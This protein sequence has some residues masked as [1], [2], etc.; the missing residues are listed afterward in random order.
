MADF[1]KLPGIP[2]INPVKDQTLSAILRPIKE[3]IEIIGN[4]VTGLPLP[5][6][7][8]IDAG[9]NPSITGGGTP[10]GSNG[11][12][13]L[14]DYTPPPAP[15]GLSIQ[16]AFSNILLDW[17]EPTYANHAYTEVW[18]AT[19]NSLGAAVLIGFAPGL[20][21]SDSVG[22]HNTYYYWIR[23]VSQAN[24]AGPYNG[25]TG[26]VGI[27]ALDPAYALE[28]LT[29]QIT[30]TQLYSTLSNT[31]NLITA[32][33]STANSVNARV[34]QEASDRAAAVLAEASARATQDQVLQTQIDT[35]VAASSGDFQDLIA[36]I[37]TE[38]TAR[39]AADTAEATARETLAAQMRGTYTGTDV[40]LVTTG[41]MYSER[42]ARASADG[43]LSSSITALSST[44]S[45]NYTTLNSAI[46]TE[47]TTRANADTALSSS[48][49]SVSAIASSKN[50][51]YRQSTA[52]TSPVAGDVWYDTSAENLS[53]RWNGSLW[54]TVQDLR[55]G[56][57]TAAITA[58][59]TARAN[60]DTA[61]ATSITNLTSTVNNNYT[62]LNSAITTESSTRASADTTLSNQITTLQSTVTTNNNTLTA[63]ISTE[64][65]T[66]A[67][68]D[69]GLLAQYTVKVDVNGRVAG[70]GLAST[71]SGGTPTSSFIVIADKFAIVK[72]ADTGGTPVVPFVVGTVDG[73]ST[74]AI[75][76]AVIQDA[77]IT[78]AKIAN[79]AVDSAKIAN[80]AIVSAKIAD[81]NIVTA[82]IAD[83]AI[84]TAKIAN[85]SIGT[86][87]IANAAINTALI[88]DAA[89]TTAKI[90]DANITNV[91]IA[92]AA[93][94]TAKIG[95]AAITTAKIGDATITGAKIAAATIGS[96]NIGDAQITNAK[97]GNAEV[98]T[99]KIA[100]NA[101]TLPVAVYTDG[102]VTVLYDQG[103]GYPTTVQSA[104]ISSSGAP[105]L[106][107]FC[108][109]TDA[110]QPDP[111]TGGAPYYGYSLHRNGAVLT[112]GLLS[113]FSNETLVINFVDTAG[114]GYYTYELRMGASG[115]TYGTVRKR[116]LSIL[117]VK[118]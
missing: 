99:I 17:D 75:S 97:I 20:V 4:A 15:T 100:G 48:I 30:Q 95:D 53:K 107:S 24:V 102:G 57:N 68:V 39:I 50:V 32:P 61:L 31:I 27:T 105:K 36:A 12:D 63:A 14:I 84:T 80:A 115:A 71:T 35:L 2:S 116:T 60:A 103:V 93:I 49:S 114:A 1:P 9:F 104:G 6:G 82:K 34:A 7:Q 96:A 47:Q 28:V 29:G 44:V 108:C 72:P 18:R 22:T 74:V 89:I 77:A 87:Q 66:R 52:P 42:T 92:D 117:E 25:V 51:T 65:S 19:T 83:A 88:S 111:N 13:P 64:A 86:A 90:A 76:N 41:L 81:A 43:A 78:N 62:T 110:I 54:E 55:I 21:Y 46:T 112:S 11:Y 23:F 67:S 70:F 109:N 16:G 37:E 98:D 10:T 113:A 8:I 38:Q 106:I 118:R 45:S 59:Q 79:L 73:V 56:T 101:V 69:G 40:A 3:S 94:T 5:N 85:A 91:K 26:T 58:E 33:S